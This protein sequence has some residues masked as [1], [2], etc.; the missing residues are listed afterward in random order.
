MSSC[1]SFFP[2]A[3]LLRLTRMRCAH[4]IPKPPH[5]AGSARCVAQEAALEQPKL[6]SQVVHGREFYPLL[7][8]QDN[9]LAMPAYGHVSQTQ[10]EMGD[11]FP[12]SLTEETAARVCRC[13]RPN[14][15]KRAHVDRCY[16]GTFVSPVIWAILNDTKG[17]NP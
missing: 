16:T 14:I 13:I 10:C 12:G 9:W 15:D 11:R 6:C 8:I 4:R 3:F 2:Q 5:A 7:R 17:V 1:R